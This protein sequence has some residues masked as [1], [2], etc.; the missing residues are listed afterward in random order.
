MSSDHEN[1]QAVRA[2]IIILSIAG[3]AGTFA[4]RIVDPLVNVIALDLDASVKAIALLATAFALPYAL[5]QPVLG[6][7]GDA[8]GKLRVM[9]F[10]LAILVM[11]LIA[12]AFM[13]DAQSL[14]VMRVITGIAAGGII[15]LALA[16][17]GDRVGMEDRQ[18]AITRFLVAVILGQLAGSS[19]SGLLA[20]VVGWRG[21]FYVAAAIAGVAFLATSVGV[22][23]QVATRSV[24]S[25]A[26]AM[27]RYRELLANPRAR[28]L[29]ALVFF[30]AIAIMGVLPFI[31]PLL[32]ERDAGGPTQA[33][34][35]LAGFAVGGLI[36]S[37][38]VRWMLRRLGIYRMLI[39]GGLSSALALASLGYL[40]DWRSVTAAL[41][42]LGLGFYMMHN[43]FQTQVTELSVEARG[44]AVALHACSFF[45]GGAAG[46]VIFGYG[47]TIFGAN[48]TLLML[49]LLI[50]SLGFIAAW[51]LKATAPQLRAR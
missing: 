24:F 38:L 51:A 13:P 19:L 23:G 49:A 36:Y 46:P 2:T 14:F 9:R 1:T 22:R 25:F 30:E 6:P 42:L 26:V 32:A 41:T 16:T 40:D 18:V 4:G 5:I 21:V 8:L 11:A 12:S 10:C 29:F 3:F 33:G 20:D 7:F 45:C 44:S 50:F 35:A 48:A 27:T 47:S 37:G 34:I 28:A 39:G 43:S 17:I 31:A 15:P